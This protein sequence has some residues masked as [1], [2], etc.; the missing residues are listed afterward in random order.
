MYAIE[1]MKPGF[2]KVTRSGLH[3]F[4]TATLPFT[5]PPDARFE[6]VGGLMT[7]S[8]SIVLLA[9]MRLLLAD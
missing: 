4:I 2:G 8:L 1:M 7:V 3:R 9:L 6:I 5:P